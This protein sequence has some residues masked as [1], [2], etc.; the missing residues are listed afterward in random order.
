MSICVS[1][2]ATVCMCGGCFYV[3]SEKVLE[4]AT[5]GAVLVG[6]LL[7]VINLLPAFFIALVL[8]KYHLH[9]LRKEV[10]RSLEE[11]AYLHPEY[12]G[13]LTR[14][15]EDFGEPKKNLR[16]RHAQRKGGRQGYDGSVTD[17]DTF[18]HV[19]TC[20][21]FRLS[22]HVGSTELFT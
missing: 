7:P 19:Y 20:I 2:Y 22:V 13:L 12:H 21:R 18:L 15:P 9:V 8:R 16:R 10:K 1:M 17:A 3:K 5:S 6:V 14:L 11:N 4:G